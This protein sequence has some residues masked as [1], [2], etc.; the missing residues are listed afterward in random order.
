LHA[1]RG[2]ERR[3]HP[4]APPLSLDRRG[5]ARVAIR[6]VGADGWRLS[7][8]RGPDTLGR[9]GVDLDGPSRV[10]LHSLRVTPAARRTGLGAALVGAALRVGRGAGRQCARLIA[11]DD[12]TGRLVAWYRRLGFAPTGRGTPTRPELARPTG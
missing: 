3:A 5:P 2:L 10:F 6:R 11:A 4:F 7:I 9:I 8:V 1:A 12:G